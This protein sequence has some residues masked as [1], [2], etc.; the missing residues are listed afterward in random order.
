MKKKYFYAVMSCLMFCSF[1]TNAQ[2]Q[3]ISATYSAG[4]IPTAYNAYDPTCN[5]AST[6]LT[7][8][9][10]PVTGSWEV[11]SVDIEYDMTAANVAYMSEQRS[12]VKFQN[13]G[14]IEPTESGTGTG[15]TFS[16]SRTG[17]TF[18]NGFYAGNTDLIFEMQAWRTWGDT[19]PNNGCGTYYNKVDNNSWVVTVNYQIPPTCLPPSNVQSG[20][21]TTTSVDITWVDMN[22]VPPGAWNIEYGAPGFALG[23]GTTHVATGSPT[24]INGLAL[25]TDYE[26][27]IQSDC[28]TVDGVSIWEGPYDFSTTIDCSV[29]NLDITNT[30]DQT[31]ACQGTATLTAT[32]SGTGDDI[33]WYDAAIGGNI[34][35]TGSSFTTPVISTTTSYWASEIKMQSGSGGAT[36]TYC[37]P[38]YSTGCTVGD[39]I[40]DFDMSSAGISHTGTGCSTGSYADYTNDPSLVGVMN[41]GSTYTFSATHNFSSQY[42]K[43]WIDLDQDGTFSASEL[44]FTS[45]GGSNNTTGSITIPAANGGATVMRVMDSY[46]SVPTDA[47]NPG[48]TYGET[49]D[50]KVIIS[51]VACESPREEVVATVDTNGDIQV[52]TVPYN[53]INDTANYGDPFEGN[54]GSSCGTTENYLNGNDVVYK[55]TAPNTELVDVLMSDLSGFYA[56]VFIYDN[57]GTI[58]GTCLA[59][60][61]AGPSDDDFG[62]ED[63]SVTA[64]E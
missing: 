4:D 40:D 21:A 41:I 14:F 64:G 59:G 55:F 51:D 53:N 3:T 2:V 23:T 38:T 61:V 12:Q 36:P 26:F 43:I 11:V 63:F 54:P 31:I 44:L 6:A 5:G 25:G 1:L 24:T 56:S 22:A 47:C 35:G 19:A 34:V 8:T 16:Y 50:Y 18:A 15:G 13:T 49:H 17:L 46:A 29:Y 39:D 48:T 58:G 30:V 45:A 60:A 20:N 37:I 28:G 10:P 57:C 9:L 7:V 27:Y 33:Y 62:I 32:S 52:T 42:L